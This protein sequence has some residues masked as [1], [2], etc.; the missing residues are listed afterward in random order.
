MRNFEREKTSDA[1]GE[2]CARTA[3]LTETNTDGRTS[4]TT[5]GNTTSHMEHDVNALANQAHTETQDRCD[6]GLPSEVQVI[7]GKSTQVA[8]KDLLRPLSKDRPEAVDK[9]VVDVTP[10]VCTRVRGHPNNQG[11]NYAKPNK[12]LNQRVVTQRAPRSTG[13][14][15]I[16]LPFEKATDS[17]RNTY[18]YPADLKGGRDAHYVKTK[19][20][21]DAADPR[22]E[23]QRVP[24]S[25]G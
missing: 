7:V 13:L 18:E 8:D 10:E 19:D 22:V 25:M 4:N 9:E 12:Q 17:V 21:A 6:P 1:D 15:N 3:L 14:A 11:L 2:R 24:R 5:R 16:Q 23:T 20:T